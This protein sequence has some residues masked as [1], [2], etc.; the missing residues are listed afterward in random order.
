MYL[1]SQVSQGH[2]IQKVYGDDIYVRKDV[3]HPG[4]TCPDIAF[5][6][7]WGAG[8]DL[9]FLRDHI[10]VIEHMARDQNED[11]TFSDEEGSF[12]VVVVYF[13][14]EQGVTQVIVC[15]SVVYILSDEGKTLDIHRA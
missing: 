13:K 5:Q 2:S 9:P 14:N 10:S 12:V 3:L 15:D 1:K 7:I 8:D 6:D 4:K 11:G